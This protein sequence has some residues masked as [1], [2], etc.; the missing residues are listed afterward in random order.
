MSEN[1]DLPDE[2]NISEDWKIWFD[3]Y[4][5][6]SSKCN[7]GYNRKCQICTDNLTGKAVALF[8]EK[9]SSRVAVSKRYLQEYQKQFEDSSDSESDSQPTKKLV[10]H[11]ILR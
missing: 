8:N 11:W 3:G 5:V 1:S 4:N 9:L 10:S 6:D 2:N 7:I